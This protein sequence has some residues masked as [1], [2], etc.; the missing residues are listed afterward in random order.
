MLLDRQLIVFAPKSDAI[1]KAVFF[2]AKVI[3]LVPVTAF[4]NYTSSSHL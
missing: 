1:I 3:V 2:G 4:C